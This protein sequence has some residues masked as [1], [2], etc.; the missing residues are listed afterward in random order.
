MFQLTF[1]WLRM[2]AKR[3]GAFR[4]MITAPPLPMR[5]A[6]MRR[7][8]IVTLTAW[9]PSLPVSAGRLLNAK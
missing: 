2:A 1:I 3:F 8:I 5:N 4:F 6:T 7:T 9:K